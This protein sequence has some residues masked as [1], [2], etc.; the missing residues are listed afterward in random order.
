MLSELEAVDRLQTT[1]RSSS[2]TAT[3]STLLAKAADAKVLKFDKL[4]ADTT[5]VE[6]DVA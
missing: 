6:A 1:P 2:P 4:R 3:T 5:V